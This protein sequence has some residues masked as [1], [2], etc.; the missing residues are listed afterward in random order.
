LDTR[1]ELFQA[2]AGNRRTFLKAAATG[3]AAV[4]TAEAQSRQPNVILIC[5][6][7]LGYGDLGSYGGT[8][9][10]P[11]LDLIAQQGIRFTH[12]TSACAVCSPARASILTGRYPNRYGIP[13]VI[14][15]DDT[16]GL[17]ASETTIAQMMKGLNYST[18][19][20]GKWHLGSLPQ[21]LP[22]NHG[23]DQFYGIPYSADMYPLP[24]MHNLDIVEQPTDVSLLLQKYTQWAVNYIGN[25]GSN[26][27]FMYY[28]PSA[29]HL[30]LMPSGAFSGMS[31]QG[32]YGDVVMELD[33][34]V[35]SIMQALKSS[36]LD[37][38]TLVIFTSDHGPWYQ[39]STGGLRQRKGEIFEGGVRVPLLARYPGAIPPG[40]VS[41]TLTTSLDFLPTIAAFTGAALPFNPLD[42][43]DI[44]PVLRGWQTDLTRDAFLYFNDVELQA[45]RLGPWKLHVTRFNS[46]AFS[47]EPAG[48]RLNLPLPNSELYNVTQD[49]DESHDRSLRNPDQVTAI[50]ARMD[51]LIQ[52][53]PGGIV[54]AWKNTL[55]YQVQNTS[56]GA[57]PVQTAN[58]G[59]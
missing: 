49:L 18:T 41:S 28:A 34:S 24:L 51:A 38:N 11:N 14:D 5:C 20:I 47:P 52:T 58:P 2:L 29:P 50:R 7:D 9:R 23:F 3:A 45:A 30:P 22:T 46:W 59:A 26:P 16:Y 10:T 17:P 13:R 12:Q 32:L 8:I 21:F 48:G 6:D 35:G 42:G 37:S 40:Q 25:A 33:A 39:G 43:I 36:G 57:L 15:P 44:T 54:G 1:R 27:F 55:S 4:I 19:C 53:F 31:G 56:V